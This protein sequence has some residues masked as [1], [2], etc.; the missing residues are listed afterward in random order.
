MAVKVTGL[1]IDYAQGDFRQSSFWPEA[2][3]AD[4]DII[5]AGIEASGE[6]TVLGY[7][8]CNEEAVMPAQVTGTAGIIL[9][10]KTM[11]LKSAAGLTVLNLSGKVP[12]DETKLKAIAAIAITKTVSGVAIDDL[13]ISAGTKSYKV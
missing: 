6:V 8:V 5:K 12:D 4:F 10:H 1:S 3:E 11:A 2:T 13:T 7:S 9:A